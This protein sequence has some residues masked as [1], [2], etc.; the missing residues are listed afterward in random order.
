MSDFSE[1]IEKMNK[2][3]TELVSPELE[4]DPETIALEMYEEFWKSNPVPTDV[5]SKYGNDMYRID[6]LGIDA[7]LGPV[8][9][10]MDQLLRKSKKKGEEERWLFNPEK[11]DFV[12]SLTKR[13][14]YLVPRHVD[15][16]KGT[17][18]VPVD[19]EGRQVEYEFSP[20]ADDDETVRLYSIMQELS[21]IAELIVLHKWVE[22]GLSE[23]C[24]FE[25][26]FTH[27][28]VATIHPLQPNS[29]NAECNRIIFPALSQKLLVYL[30]ETT[31]RELRNICNCVIKDGISLKKGIENVA[32]CYGMKSPKYYSQKYNAW[33]RFVKS[34]VY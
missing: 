30:I 13:A 8:L 26:F 17:I 9:E 21:Y 12:T 2:L 24:H 31:I 25:G 23:T 4:R 20:G 14:K 1:I 34:E 11:G 7:P 16:L 32:A 19:E 3:G 5:T 27:D 29:I 28:I 18:Q 6:L 22:L 10:A 15:M 33:V